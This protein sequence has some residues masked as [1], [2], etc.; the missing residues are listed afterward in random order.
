MDDPLHKRLDS[1]GFPGSRIAFSGGYR[2]SVSDLF[3]NKGRVRIVM[4]RF[5]CSFPEL[6]SFS[7]DALPS[8]CRNAF[9]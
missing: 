2:T 8:A 9:G 3:G 7:A 6:R 1:N 5:I 4:E